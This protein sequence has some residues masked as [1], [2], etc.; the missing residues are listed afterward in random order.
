MKVQM[1]TLRLTVMMTRIYYR[2]DDGDHSDENN[3]DMNMIN[4]QDDST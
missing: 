4:D 3:D 1:I 2:N